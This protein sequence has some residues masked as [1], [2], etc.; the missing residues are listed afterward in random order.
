MAGENFLLQKEENVAKVIVNRPKPRNAFKTTMW[1]ELIDIF[2]KCFLSE[3]FRECVWAFLEKR[4]P[5]FKG[6]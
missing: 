4:K 3:D 1:F 5:Q 2:K 6:R